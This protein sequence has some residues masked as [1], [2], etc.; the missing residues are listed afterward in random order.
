M[1]TSDTANNKP[2]I[3]SVVEIVVFKVTDSEKGLKAANAILEDAQAFNNAV[4]SADVYQSATDSN[5]IAQRIVWKSLVEAKAA[6]A[7]SD[8]FPGMSA[9]Q[10]VM[11]ELVVFDHFYKG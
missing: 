8:T 5:T 9:L 4:V 1:N 11:T 3:S 10:N 6:Q 2:S 7:A